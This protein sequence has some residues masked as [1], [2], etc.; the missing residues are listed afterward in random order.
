MLVVC[1]FTFIYIYFIASRLFLITN[2]P[3]LTFDLLLLLYFIRHSFSEGGLLFIFSSLY[4]QLS[5]P[6]KILICY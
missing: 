1:L 3:T 4:I 6:R 5:I 2:K